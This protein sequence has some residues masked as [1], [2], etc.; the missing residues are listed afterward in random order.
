M[1]I[2]S[3]N[4]IGFGFRGKLGGLVF[5]NVGGKTIVSMQPS[6]DS[7]RKTSPRQQ[8]ARTRFSEAVAFARLATR[9]PQQKLFF[10]REARRMGLANA[11]I[12]A[13]TLY[14]R[15]QKDITPATAGAQTWEATK[16]EPLNSYGNRYTMSFS[17][18][19]TQ[20]TVTYNLC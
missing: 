5:R 1:A 7:K 18:N 15:G 13:V 16:Q 17:V 6:A 9:N 14:L 19:T 11:Y 10:A 8:Q 12:A 2:V 20:Y 4:S 3:E